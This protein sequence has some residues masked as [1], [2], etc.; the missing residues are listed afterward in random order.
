[1]SKK[2]LY[3]ITFVDEE[4]IFEIYA[5]TICE[6]EMFGFIEVSDFVFGENSAIVVDPSEEKLKLA[7]SEVK[8]SL[9]PAHSIIRIDVVEKEGVARAKGKRTQPTSNIS[10]FPRETHRE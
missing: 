5:R 4:E 1:M 9:I 8:T 6:S 10:Q 2:H 3:R 7:F